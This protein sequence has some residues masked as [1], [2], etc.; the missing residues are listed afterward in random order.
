VRLSLAHRPT[1]AP[2]SAESLPAPA[3]VQQPPLLDLSPRAY[4]LVASVLLLAYLLLWLT[5]FQY[6]YGLIMDDF[7]VYDKGLDTIRDW[8]GAFGHYNAHHL[9]SFLISYLPLALGASL[10]SYTVPFLGEQT[11]Q[12]RFFQLSAV[13]LHVA[14]LGVWAWFATAVGV[15]RLVSFVALLL[16]ATSPTFVLWTPKPDSRLL[17]LPF[18]LLALWLLLRVDWRSRR[19]DRP[20]L[21]AL[22]A[23][24]SLLGMAESIHYTAFYLLAPVSLAFTVGWLWGRWRVRGAWLGLAVFALGCAWLHALW[25]GLSYF[26]VGIPWQQG[27]TMSVLYF[28]NEHGTTWSFVDTVAGRVE[29]FLSQ[30]GP[31]ELALVGL[32]GAGYLVGW[33]SGGRLEPRKRLMVGGAILLGLLYLSVSGSLPF[34]RQT[35]VLQPFLF[36]FAAVGMVGLAR[37]LARRPAGRATLLVGLLVVA[38]VVQ[39]RQAAAV[40]QAHQA[41]GHA[42]AWAYAN[43]GERPLRWLPLAPTG[44]ATEVTS[45]RELDEAPANTWLLSYF[46]WFFLA[47]HPSL[48]PALEAT[49][50]VA[51]WPSLYATDA[52]QAEAQLFGF[53][54]FRADRLLGEVQVIDGA[55]VRDALRGPALTVRRVVAD[56]QASAATEPA[57]LF[58]RDA[59]ADGVTA[60]V[61]AASPA[62]H[63]VEV[64]FATP[65]PL[66]AVEVVSPPRDYGGRSAVGSRLDDLEIQVADPSGEYRS[67]WRGAHLEKYPVV[68]ASWPPQ[69]ASAIR[70]VVRGQRLPM[71]SIPD[72]AIEEV[73]F[74]GYTVQGPPATR[75]APPLELDDVSAT[76]QGLLVSGA[77]V[78]PETV[79]VVDGR[80]LPSRPQGTARLLALGPASLSETDRH[81]MYLTDGPR[82]SNLVRWPWAPPTLD[83]LQPASA[84]VDT[85]FNAQPDG[86]SVLEVHG[87]DLTPGTTVLFDT[88]TLPT[89]YV[90]DNVLTAT[91][92]REFLAYSSRHTITLQNSRGTSNALVFEIEP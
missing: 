30:L 25:E 80:P 20:T 75:P 43:K 48:R 34:F 32:G 91:V 45:V 92:P 14:L 5:H 31:L 58:D 56:S 15:N 84:R 65:V 4:L 63:S 6:V 7:H 59:A 28:R 3:A 36:L 12:F 10:P 8:R 44:A 46:P 67:V 35:S 70:L 47:A 55:A 37:R 53:T 62:P 23:A 73:V 13:C 1:V 33:P 52:V 19:V 24:G 71:Q 78:T 86:R 39:W 66:G 69:A 29:T 41:L 61:S 18:M 22:F 68:A 89:R 50:P 90:D 87:A 49:A 81:E 54:D 16:L 9:Y 2:A 64:E 40:F 88:V 76:P 82:R 57:N 27:P 42:L 85:P 83:A 77:N 60:W 21:V 17:G 74:P 79:L 11:G 72:A 26:V 51:A 38:G